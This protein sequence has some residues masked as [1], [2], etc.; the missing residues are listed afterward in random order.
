[1]A[2]I[3]IIVA[4]VLGYAEWRRCR[5]EER[6]DMIVLKMQNALNDIRVDSIR[7]GYTNPG[8]K[9]EEEIAR[10]LDIMEHDLDYIGKALD[11][12]VEKLRYQN[13]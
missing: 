11:R 5:S 6:I 4:L 10:Q 3:A 2:F 1:M 8:N 12:V 7:R 9:A 13:L